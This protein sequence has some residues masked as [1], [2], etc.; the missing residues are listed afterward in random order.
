M[1]PK[2]I[3]GA[4]SRS[5]QQ[6]GQVMDGNTVTRSLPTRRAVLA[7]TSASLALASH[8]LRAEP[9]GDKI[10]PLVLISKPQAVDPAQYQAAQLA[11][12]LSAL[13]EYSR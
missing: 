8:G 7:G 11:L 2:P 4:G 10:R 12:H 6:E 1:P 3:I 9:P 13:E 5:D